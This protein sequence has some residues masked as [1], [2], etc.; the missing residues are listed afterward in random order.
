MRILQSILK[1]TVA[2]RQGRRENGL[3]GFWLRF[4]SVAGLLEP[5]PSPKP[6]QNPK[7]LVS[8]GYSVF[9]N[10]PCCRLYAPGKNDLSRICKIKELEQKETKGTKEN[11]FGRSI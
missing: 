10:A 1:N 3:F 6:R 5:A 7:I 9:S 11:E 4:G 2:I 8:N